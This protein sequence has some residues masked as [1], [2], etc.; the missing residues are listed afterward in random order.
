MRLLV[1]VLVFIIPTRHPKC[2]AHRHNLAD[3]RAQ[4]CEI[5]PTSRAGQAGITDSATALIPLPL[6]PSTLFLSRARSLSLSLSLSLCVCV[7]T[8][9][10]H[11]PMMKGMLKAMLVSGV[12][13][14]PTANIIVAPACACT[15][16]KTALK[17]HYSWI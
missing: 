5:P 15:Q 8:C 7:C 16:Y 12:V 2:S 14:V 6:H 11:L 9:L 13:M 10:Q 17:K 4:L 1:L 3:M